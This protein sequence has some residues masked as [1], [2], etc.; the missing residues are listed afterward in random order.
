MLVKELKLNLSGDLTKQQ[1]AYFGGS[2][3]LVDKLRKFGIGSSKLVYKSGIPAFD[4]V[5]RGVENEMSFV[6]FE[7]LKNGLILWLN[8]NQRTK[9]VGVKLTDVKAIHLVAYRIE[10]QYEQYHRR[11]RKIVHRGE[12]EIIDIQNNIASF[13]ALAQNFEGILEFFQK[14]EF[15][16]KLSHSIS[17]NP[18]EKDSGHLLDAL[19]GI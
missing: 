3:P 8:Q 17:L 13:E 1:K 15:D 7:L 14:V 11:V 5:A 9:A 16:S 18:P 6:N 2:Y 19:G 4:E 12:L 10:V